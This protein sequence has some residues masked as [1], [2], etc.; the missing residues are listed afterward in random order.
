MEQ[1]ERE[2]FAET[3][4][5]VFDRTDTLPDDG[6]EAIGWRDALAA[7]GGPAISIVLGA[8]GRACA[9][10]GAIDDVVAGALGLDAAPDAVLLPRLGSQQPPT[11]ASDEGVTVAGVATA[12]ILAATRVAVAVGDPTGC[13]VVRVPTELL[14]VEPIL[15]VDADARL[16]S[17]TAEVATGDLE[18]G[19]S[20]DW[21]RA[22][23]FGQVSV[24]CELVGV[25]RGML[26]LAIEH[27]TSRVQF[28]RTIGSFQAVRHRLVDSFIAL[29]GAS[30]AAAACCDVMIGD[31][32]D[33]GSAG[34]LPSAHAAMAKALAGDA[35]RTAAKHAQ[36][37]LAGIGFTSEHRFHHY[38][39]RTLL[40]DRL[41]GSR[42]AITQEIGQTALD[43]RR[44]PM[45]LPL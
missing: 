19:P 6:L 38:F 22:L 13:R 8:Q 1:S 29:E 31:G 41:L 20:V 12:R 3:V 11:T 25:G 26:E 36:Q 15:G 37:V 39:R 21:A 40:L 2:Q 43:A 33:G 24:A 16:F 34:T 17:V 42:T 35:A 7:W 30:A 14:T 4:R 23:A 10:S 28:G 27:A 18:D 45:D 9:T 5:K 32:P 44:V